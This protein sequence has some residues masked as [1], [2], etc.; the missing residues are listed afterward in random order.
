[1]LRLA[2]GMDRLPD[3]MRARQAAFLIAAQQPDGGF[4]GRDGPSDLYYTGFGLRGLALLGALEGTTA[5]RAAEFLA[6]QTRIQ[7]PLVDFVSLVYGAALLRSSVGIDPFKLAEPNWPAAVAHALEQFRRADGGYAKTEQGQ[8]SS[9]YHTFLVVLCQQLLGLEPP[10]PDKLVAFVRSR[11]RDDGG[12][13][14]VGPMRSS[15]TNPTAAAA[16]L[17]KI[18]NALDESTREA[19][20]DFLA[21]RQGDEGGLA[22]NKRIP[23]ADLLSTFTGLMTLADFDALDRIDLQATRTYARSLEIESGGFRAAAWDDASDVEYTF[24]GLGS[25]ALAGG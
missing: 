22:A 24:Y 14:E 6:G 23:L 10:G 19:V 7:A 1:M 16:A 4:A 17:L 15:G 21:D 5:Q 3:E 9:T 2:G 20:I 13:V 18:L 8:S 11:Q 25:L 12:F